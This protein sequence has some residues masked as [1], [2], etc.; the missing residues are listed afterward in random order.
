VRADLAREARL[1]MV[2]VAPLV[3]G[4]IE[5]FGRHCL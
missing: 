5:V 1:M 2:G 4:W 3:I